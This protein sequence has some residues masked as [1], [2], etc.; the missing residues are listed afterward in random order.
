MAELFLIFPHLLDI[1][2]GVSKAHSAGPTLLHLSYLPPFMCVVSGHSGA[3]YLLLKHLF[4]VIFVL[5]VLQVE[6]V[7]ALHQAVN[8]QVVLDIQCLSNLAVP[9][10][11]VVESICILT[12]EVEYPILLAIWCDSM[13]L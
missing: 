10:D 12:H 3:C 13:N 11:L 5:F 1:S 6:A 8:P 9:I 4:E 2:R 7:L